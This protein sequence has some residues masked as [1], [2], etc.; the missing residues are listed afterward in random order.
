[1]LTGFSTTLRYLNGNCSWRITGNLGGIDFQ[2][3][4]V[5]MGPQRILFGNGN[6][7]RYTLKCQ[8]DDLTTLLDAVITTHGK[9]ME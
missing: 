2:N 9:Y 1:M 5:S 8:I 4:E 7:E 3:L 6:A